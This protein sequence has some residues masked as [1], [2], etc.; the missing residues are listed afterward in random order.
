VIHPKK[1][2]RMKKLQV[3]T[4]SMILSTS[5]MMQAKLVNGFSD[6]QG[7]NPRSSDARKKASDDRIAEEM[8]T[9]VT[10]EQLTK[11]TDLTKNYI[12]SL[13]QMQRPSRSQLETAVKAVIDLVRASKQLGVNNL[14]PELQS[15][16]A[17]IKTKISQ[18]NLP[19]QLK[20]MLESMIQ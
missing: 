5:F 18:L 4:L 2:C 19:S 17:S 12:A 13:K 14:S 6:I 11:F 20:N 10:K 9:P 8:G 1:G 3:L 15:Q 16:I 7:S